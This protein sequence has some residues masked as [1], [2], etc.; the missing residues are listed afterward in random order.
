MNP[1]QRI[2]PSALMEH[3]G[4][5]AATAES[6]AEAEAFLGA[7]VPLAARLIPRVAPTIMRVAPTLI[8]GVAG[9]GRTLLRSPTF[10]PLSALCRPS[11]AGQYPI[12]PGRSPRV[13]R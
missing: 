12:S 3:L 13:D 1:Q 9:A 7:L 2:Y 11:S 4:H 6:E 10:A 8:R 5:A